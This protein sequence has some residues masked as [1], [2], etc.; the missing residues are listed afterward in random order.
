MWAISTEEFERGLEIL[1]RRNRYQVVKRKHDYLL[2]G[3]IYVE[4]PGK[5][6][7]IKLTGSTSNTRRAGGGTA[8]YCVPSNDINSMCNKIDSQIPE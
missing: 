7:L 2:K 3:M 1:A 5:T 8:Y 6:H 4:I